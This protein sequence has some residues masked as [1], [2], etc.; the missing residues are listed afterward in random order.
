MKIEKQ[1]DI[2]DNPN[3]RDFHDFN[4]EWNATTLKNIFS[5]LFDSFSSPASTPPVIQNL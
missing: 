4:L 1:L 2:A 3:T 5:Q